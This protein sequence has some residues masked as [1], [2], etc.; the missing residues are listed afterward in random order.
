MCD[1]NKKFVVLFV[2]HQVRHIKLVHSQ[3][4][5]LSNS[6]VIGE[7]GENLMHNGETSKNNIQQNR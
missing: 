2:F 7:G 6:P 1:R 3:V 5:P 4:Q